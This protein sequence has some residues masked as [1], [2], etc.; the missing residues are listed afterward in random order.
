M[1]VSPI[2]QLR[3]HSHCYF[4][5]VGV[6]LFSFFFFLP[7]APIISLLWIT[8]SLRRT[9]PQQ[10]SIFQRISDERAIIERAKVLGSFFLSFSSPS[11]FF[12]DKTNE[13]SKRERSIALELAEKWNNARTHARKQ[14][15]FLPVE[16]IVPRDS[17]AMGVQLRDNSRVRNRDEAKL[18]SSF[19]EKFLESATRLNARFFDPQISSPSSPS[20]LFF[21]RNLIEIN[22][23]ED[24]SVFDRLVYFAE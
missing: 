1:F 2:G 3:L 6:F 14:L 4:F 19:V 7:P 5:W 20:F 8:I 9:K 17:F 12:F 13:Q 23:K 21:L 11:L 18:F 22:S 10:L 16:T 15:L 24:V